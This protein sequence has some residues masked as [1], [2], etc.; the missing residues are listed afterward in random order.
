ML[1]ASLSSSSFGQSVTFTATIYTSSPGLPPSGTVAFYDG[2]T[3][4]ATVNLAAIGSSYQA[5]FTTSSLSRG[6]HGITATYGGDQNFTGSTS[7]VSEFV[8]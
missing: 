4:L 3:L 1:S 2:T 5:A 6:M 7:N 8:F